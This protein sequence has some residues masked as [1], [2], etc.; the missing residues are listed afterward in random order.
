[1]NSRPQSGDL[2]GDMANG[3]NDLLKLVGVN[4]WPNIDLFR[5]R[6]DPSDTVVELFNDGS[7]ASRLSQIVP[8]PY[9]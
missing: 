9:S 2:L 3:I 1:M 6:F 5:S 8:V 4:D 7:P